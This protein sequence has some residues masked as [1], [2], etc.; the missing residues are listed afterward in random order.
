M[1]K[2]VYVYISAFRNCRAVERNLAKAVD[3]CK[4]AS[5]VETNTGA[6]TTTQAATTAVQATTSTTPNAKCNMKISQFSIKSPCSKHNE[7]INFS[8]NPFTRNL[9]LFT[10]RSMF[11]ILVEEAKKELSELT[12]KKIVKQQEL[13]GNVNYNYY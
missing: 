12:D 7:Y 10:L 9:F 1:D 2:Y 6:E 3:D 13:V 11:D 4:V 5:S 8:V